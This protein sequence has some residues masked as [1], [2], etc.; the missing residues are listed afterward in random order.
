MVEGVAVSHKI[1][2]FKSYGDFAE[3]IGFAYWWSFIDGGLAI[4]GA[5]PYSF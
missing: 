3:W 1:D 2:W 4:N 5:A